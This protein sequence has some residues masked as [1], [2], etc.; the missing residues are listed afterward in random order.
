MV[1]FFIKRQWRSSFPAKLRQQFCKV[2][3]TELLCMCFFFV[4]CHLRRRRNNYI[5]AQLI[6]NNFFQ[7]DIIYIY[8]QEDCSRTLFFKLLYFVLLI[9][10]LFCYNDTNLTFSFSKD[11]NLKIFC[12]VIKTRVGFE[13]AEMP[14]FLNY[15]SSFSFALKNNSS[16]NVRKF[17]GVHVY[18]GV[19]CS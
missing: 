19:V 7:T 16:E 17:S 14:R 11:T 1:R 15:I 4:D 9:T 6:A 12:Y 3:E 13:I 8:W 10:F 18:S 2:T 5:T